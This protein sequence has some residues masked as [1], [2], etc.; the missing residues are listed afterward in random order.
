MITVVNFI[1]TPHNFSYEKQFTIYSLR[2]ES[3]VKYKKKP[4]S[5][6]LHSNGAVANE[7]YTH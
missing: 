6:E 1:N 2:L 5:V 7:L 3:V 4:T